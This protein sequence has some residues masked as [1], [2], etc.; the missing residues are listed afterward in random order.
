[1]VIGRRHQIAQHHKSI[2]VTQSASYSHRRRPDNFCLTCGRQWIP[3]GTNISVQCLCTSYQTIGSHELVGPYVAGRATIVMVRTTATMMVVLATIVAPVVIGWYRGIVFLFLFIVVL[4]MTTWVSDRRRRRRER[5]Y[6]IHTDQRWKIRGVVLHSGSILPSH[7]PE[8]L[9]EFCRSITIQKDSSMP[10]PS[11]P[12]TTHKTSLEIHPRSV[13]G[14]KKKW[15]AAAQ[16]WTC[17]HCHQE[18]NAWFE[19][20]HVVPLFMGGSN[21]VNNL[22]AVCRECH[23]KKTLQDNLHQEKRKEEEKRKKDMIYL[24]HWV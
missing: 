16:H 12:C 6:V 18:L 19:V 23:G 24:H 13:S 3:R 8:C 20:D 21:E 10:L 5:A 11:T 22:A 15:V 1:M 14:T 4:G 17:K 2:G 9:R 7:A